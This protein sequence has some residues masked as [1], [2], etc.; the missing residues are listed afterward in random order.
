MTIIQPLDREALR[1]QFA[2]ASP[3]PF[4]KIEGFLD[5]AFARRVAAA[6]PKFEDAAKQGLAFNGVNE[7][8]KVQITDTKLFAAPVAQLN[9]A[10]A[11]SEFLSDLSYITGIPDLL[12]DERLV[13]GGIHVTGPGGRLDVHIDFNYIEDRKL[14]RRVNLLLYLNSAW[15][16]EWGG[17]IQ[18]WDQEVKN[19][20][21]SFAP[22]MNRCVIFETSEI[23]FH[24]VVPVAPAAPVPRI[25]FATYYYT[26]ECPANWSGGVHS[27]V[28]RAR[29][30]ERVRG[31]VLM[32]AELIQQRINHGV[33]KIKQGVK[34]LVG[35]R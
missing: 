10:L 9:D 2:A 30:E 15:Q 12:A 20:R 5:P 17:H 27:T 33:H 4:V 21:Q 8:K 26:R 23:S 16:E 13:G 18:L 32:P 25:S 7:K 29:P 22:A 6:Y 19:C 14:Y 35:A 3:F 31:Y 1:Q 11:S 28:F 24:G 34:R